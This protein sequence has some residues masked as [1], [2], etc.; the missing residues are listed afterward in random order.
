[1]SVTPLNP[2]ITVV[3][4]RHWAHEVVLTREALAFLV[5]LSSFAPRIRQLLAERG[6]RQQA[7]ESGAGLDV[8]AETAPVRQASW[9]VAPVPAVLA[10]RTVQVVGPA[11]PK[12]ILDGLNSGA[13]VFVADLE[14][15]SAPTFDTII[16][17]Q[18]HLREAVAGTL[19]YIAPETGKAFALCEEPAQLCVRP[20]GLHLL[21]PHLCVDGQ[22]L[23]AALVDFGLFFF[24]NAGALLAK[25]AVPFVELAKLESHREAQLW[26]EIF[27]FA[28]E[29]LGMARGTLRATVIIETVTAAFAPQEILHA[30]REHAVGLSLGRANYL[31]RLVQAHGA[32]RT[33][34]LPDRSQL[35]GEQPFL[36]ALSRLLV[37]TCHAHGA[38]AL[39]PLA[40]Q[41]PIR[42][43][44]V[45]HACALEKLRADLRCDVA[46]GFDGCAVA[47]AALVPVARAV[48]SADR[49]EAQPP[50]PT[51]AQE[52]LARPVGAVTEAG[53]R[54]AIRVGVQVLEAW[55]SG[56]GCIALEG[57]REDASTAELCRALLWQW[58]SHGAA[59]E[60]GRV[61][62]AALFRK[63][64]AEELL[65]LEKGVQGRRHGPGRLAIAAGLFDRLATAPRFEPFLTLSAYE[66]LLAATEQAA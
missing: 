9:A 19:N 40:S 24:H 23:P 37:E 27:V 46:D 32:D 34:I 29:A 45:A 60:D 15:A 47:H 31:A 52:L 1:M 44:A 43:D 4:P 41:L 22:P 50:R 28:Q 49:P 61:I 21:E 20:R 39:A 59:L 17:S 54:Q 55:L 6:L 18:L 11:E 12:A 58:L 66:L 16:R 36:R 25:G 8:A 2:R 53:V 5:Q 57:Q 35:L 3:G 65:K 30:L 38:H 51:T 7:L 62:D 33:R 14:D 56:Q 10:N 48:F 13:S 64:M 42:S 26:N 63:L